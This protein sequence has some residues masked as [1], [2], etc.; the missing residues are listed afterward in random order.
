MMLNNYSL[1]LLSSQK[2]RLLHEQT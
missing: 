1:Y 2:K